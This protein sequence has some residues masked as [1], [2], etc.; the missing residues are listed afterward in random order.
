MSTNID[1][2]QFDFSFDPALDTWAVGDPADRELDSSD[3]FLPNDEGR[4][5][6]LP[7]TPT[8]CPSLRTR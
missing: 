8:G 7:P 3:L 4:T 2:G 1:L 6:F 5:E